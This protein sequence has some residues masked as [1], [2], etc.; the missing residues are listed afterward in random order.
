MWNA[1]SLD[2]CCYRPGLGVKCALGDYIIDHMLH[3][4][5]PVVEQLLA[6]LWPLA[7]AD[8]GKLSS[9]VL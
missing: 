7:W 6:G 8:G 1:G 4:P 5:M 3:S 2:G 9:D